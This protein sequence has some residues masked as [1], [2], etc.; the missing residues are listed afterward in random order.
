[1]I[2]TDEPVSILKPKIEG[3]VMQTKAKVGDTSQCDVTIPKGPTG[4]DPSDIK[5]FQALKITTRIFKS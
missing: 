2:F 3:L 5:F 1:M 4:I